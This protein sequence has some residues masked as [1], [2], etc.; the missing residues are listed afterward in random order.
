MQLD[1]Q[2]DNNLARLVHCSQLA[3]RGRPAGRPAS[4]RAKALCVR[5]IPACAGLGGQSL[6]G[7]TAG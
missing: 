3:I 6:R 2:A 1:K 5:R 4:W 7:P